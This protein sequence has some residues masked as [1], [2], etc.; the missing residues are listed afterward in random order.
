MASQ[1]TRY[2]PRPTDQLVISISRELMRLDSEFP[3]CWKAE[4]VRLLLGG[5][6]AARASTGW[7]NI[8]ATADMFKDLIPEVVK[9]KCKAVSAAIGNNDK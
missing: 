2:T 5:L 4:D 3:G 7:P 1:M 8:D 9:L 6:A